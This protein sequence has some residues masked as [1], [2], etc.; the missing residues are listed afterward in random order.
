VIGSFVA[1]VNVLYFRVLRHEFTFFSE[2]PDY[3][4]RIDRFRCAAF[5]IVR[6][7]L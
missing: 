4:G 3:A 5:G 6:R 1:V 7:A 2:S